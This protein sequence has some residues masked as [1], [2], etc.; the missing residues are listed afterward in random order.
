M[1]LRIK[2]STQIPVKFN[3]YNL[4]KNQRLQVLIPDLVYSMSK[5]IRGQLIS[6]HVSIT[7]SITP[8]LELYAKRK[9]ENTR[10]DLDRDLVN[11][12]QSYKLQVK[13][14]SASTV[15]LLAATSVFL[16]PKLLPIGRDIGVS[17]SRAGA[18]RTFEFYLWTF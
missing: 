18:G 9:K 17:C 5:K 6:E 15:V 12:I 2:I 4:N 1:I 7:D 8:H 10:P 16:C 11:T 14:A 13:D 3:Q